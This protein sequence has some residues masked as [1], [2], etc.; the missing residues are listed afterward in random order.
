[1]NNNNV[2]QCMFRY[3]K[4]SLLCMFICVCLV[5]AKTL[6]KFIHECSYC[7]VIVFVILCVSV[8]RTPVKLYWFILKC[9]YSATIKNFVMYIYIAGTDKYPAKFTNI[10]AINI[11]RCY[12]FFEECSYSVT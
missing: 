6:S 10:I 4:Y 9:S 8:F 12:W 11:T 1:M 2:S 7:A 3:K 5:L